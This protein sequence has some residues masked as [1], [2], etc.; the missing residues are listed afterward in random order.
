[1]QR[2]LSFTK[3]R[4]RS[5]HLH[6]S[7]GGRGAALVSASELSSRWAVDAAGILIRPAQ[8]HERVREM[9]V[10]A[11]LGRLS[12]HRGAADLLCARRAEGVS[13]R[14]SDTNPENSCQLGDI[15][16]AGHDEITV[17]MPVNGLLTTEKADINPALRRSPC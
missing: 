5:R 4:H 11:R 3:S 1:M 8:G 9:A 7:G 13:S 15:S 10:W 2:H 17:I 16:G 6:I 12:R 14:R